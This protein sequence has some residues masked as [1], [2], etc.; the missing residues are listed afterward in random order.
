M[1]PELADFQLYWQRCAQQFSLNRCQTQQLYARLLAAYSEPQRHYHGVQ[2]IL[3]CLQHFD[4][5][6]TQLQQPSLVELALW[7]HD[8]VYHP[9]AQDNEAQSVTLCQQLCA[10]FLT[11]AQIETVSRW[12]LATRQHQPSDEPDLNALLDID[13]AI[14]AAPPARF[15]EYQQQIHQEYAWVEQNLYQHKRRAVLMQFYQMQ[16]L[17]QT[18]YFQQHY[19]AQAKHNLAQALSAAGESAS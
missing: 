6:R 4:Q 19:E 13:L 17:Y 11:A 9:K 14:L 18:R 12:I 16:P 10:D 5:I 7:F 2:H 3:E 1:Q 15:A 8:A